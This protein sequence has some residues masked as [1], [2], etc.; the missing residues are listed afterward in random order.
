M[1]TK[2]YHIFLLLLLIVGA[3]VYFAPLLWAAPQD[4]VV[5]D[6]TPESCD[7][8]ALGAALVAD[9]TVTFNCGPNPHTIVAD[10]Y[11]INTAVVVDGGNL[12]TLDGEGLRQIFLV[13]EGASLTLR[14]MTL[15]RGFGSNGP[16]GA[17]WNFGSLLIQASTIQ[18]SGTDT[19]WAGGALANDTS[20]T[21]IIEDSIIENNSAADAAA[22]YTRGPALTITNSTIRNNFVREQG[23][24]FYGGAI[25]QE[26]N[27]EAVTTILASTLENNA[28]NPAG[29]VGGGISLLAGRLVM[30]GSTLAGNTGYGGGGA[31][32][33]GTGVTAEIRTSRFLNNRTAPANGESNFLGGAIYNNSGLLTVED[34]TFTGNEATD[35]GAIFSG[36]EGSTL[37]LRR[38]TLN[39][40]T[41][42]GGGGALL[43]FPGI[44]LI[45]NSTLSGNMA[46]IGGGI[47]SGITAELGT[48]TLINVT[49]HGNS[50]GNGAHLY[51]DDG[52]Q[53]VTVQ[54]TIFGLTQDGAACYL[55]VPLTSGGYNVEHAESCGLTGAT[56]VQ[57]TDPLLG[58]LAD[59]GGPTQTH[60][61]QPDSP[62]LDVALG[63]CLAT[64][65]RGIARPS[66]A[67]CDMGAV[68]VQADGPTPTPTDTPSPT[69]TPTPTNTPLPVPVNYVVSALE[70]TQGIQDLQN[71]VPLV[72]GKSAWVR[73][74]VYRAAGNSSPLVSAQLWRIVNG[75]YSGNPVYPSNPGGKLGPASSPSRSQLNDSFYFPIP[76][77]W[78]N[79]ANLQV[80]VEVNPQL[81]NHCSQPLI[82]IFRWWREAPE[83]TYADNVLRSPL[84][85]LQTVPPMRLWL[86][87]VVYGKR[88]GN[89]TN[90]YQANNTQLFEI[91]DWLRRAYPIS[92]LFSQRSTTTMIESEIYRW[93]KDEDDK[94]VYQ[95]QAG[96]VNQRLNLVR[97][98]DQMFNP[99][100]IRQ[101]RYYGV[102]TDTSGDFLRGLGGGFIASGPTGN[103]AATK[104]SWWDK[105]NTS[106]GDWYAGHEI[107]HTWN[108]WH[109]V[110]GG[111]VS[112]TDKGCEHSRDD[113]GYPYPNAVIGGKN[114]FIN[115]D[116]SGLGNQWIVLAP[117]RYYGFDIFLRGQVVYG[118]DWADMMSYCHKQWISD[119]TYNAIRA[120]LQAEG[121]VQAAQTLGPAGE[122]AM[123]QGEFSDDL[124]AATLDTILHL[125]SPVGQPLPEPGEFTIHLRD[126]NDT[127]LASYP[128]TPTVYEDAADN[129]AYYI[130][131]AVPYPAGVQ[132]IEVRKGDTVLTT[133][134]VSANPPTIQLITPNGGETIGEQGVTVSWSMNDA[135]GDPLA[136][137]VLFS[138]DNGQSWQT[139][140]VNITD[141]QV[142]LAF[143]TLAGTTQG[144]MRVIVT[145]GVNTVQDESDGLF[146][147]SGHTPE[148]AILAPEA[149]A[150]FVVSQT[151]ILHGSGYDVEDG[152]LPAT[153]FVWQSDRNGDLGV[154]TEVAVTTLSPGTHVI[155]L[156]VT[157]TAN[158]TTKV[159][160]TITVGEDLTTAPSLLAVAPQTIQLSAIVGSSAQPTVTLAIRDGN[161]G[162]GVTAPLTWNAT[163]TAPWLSLAQ[164]SGNA[165][166]DVR[167][168]ATTVNLATG[169]YT[170]TVTVTGSNGNVQSV[171]VQLDVLPT[172]VLP[173]TQG[174]I[175]LPLVAR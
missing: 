125:P 113:A 22:I 60:L 34:S 8:N 137:T 148:A 120:Q 130:N 159:N 70:V 100:F 79:A 121:V 42:N 117:D 155:T 44:N 104:W 15:R 164:S 39:G 102:V 88:V 136:A 65:Q 129:H 63:D 75:Q 62:A 20:G 35:G 126:A 43:L 94:D 30:E 47:R 163:T 142:A 2:F 57:N 67:A 98:I 114:K 29:A 111:Y 56:D 18:E 55:G 92:S 168:S 93:V 81:L 146:T 101:A 25:V 173:N 7:N 90:W 48:A 162:S 115:I 109:P 51:V 106:Y 10:T 73:A 175:Y 138:V 68:E 1:K 110:A 49:L 36:G 141:T 147:V 38:S 89:T 37:T 19:V 124:A 118:P 31:L 140:A 9:G 174:V 116:I 128:F 157:D 151:V 127:L 135:D 95:L 171:P 54:N 83:S 40:N 87:N 72:R 122:Y 6:G 152:M 52:S 77:D 59:N 156:Q 108:R 91:E 76:A 172:A 169:S 80:E 139:L 61:P 158:N 161:A 144:R 160:R 105:D 149:N 21:A 170:T 167:L 24:G 112:K 119:Y 82:C 86:Y 3:V 150:T 99:N 50:A 41:A 13:Q 27:A 143:D 133:R 32:Y 103:A 153:A 33:M 84:L 145:D 97:N 4:V 46:T 165:P 16:G 53:P 14:N 123:I 107:G 26:V 58:S 71:S 45:E 74:H 154:G 11:V 64:D 131:V 66:G 12:I 5:G 166:T 69:P 96:L 78:L 132:K 23:G 17:I 134:T 28:S 85:N